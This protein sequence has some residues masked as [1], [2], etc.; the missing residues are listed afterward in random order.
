MKNKLSLLPPLSSFRQFS[1]SE[2]ERIAAEVPTSIFIREFYLAVTSIAM[3]V[4]SNF[5][6]AAGA[7]YA[8]P[9][10]FSTIFHT[11]AESFPHF[12]AAPDLFMF[13]LTPLHT[14]CHPRAVNIP[15]CLRHAANFHLRILSLAR[16]FFSARHREEKIARNEH[17]EP[18]LRDARIYLLSR[19]RTQ[20]H[21]IYFNKIHHGGS[22][23]P[24]KKRINIT[25]IT[26]TFRLRDCTFTYILHIYIVN[27]FKSYE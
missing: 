18:I 13:L 16:I 17:G 14:T 20:F 2:S 25:L 3:N 19:V 15:F 27:I 9:Q 1:T 11:G 8:F 4:S 23:A 5:I 12:D 6:S 7:A 21:F 10:P 22:N 24:P 26:R